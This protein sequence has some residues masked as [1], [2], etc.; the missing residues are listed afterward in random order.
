MEFK[1]P[2]TLITGPLGSGKT[3]LLSRILAEANLR[4]AVVMNEFGEL[5][6]DSR[7][8][9]GKNIQ[10][11]ELAGGC[12]CCSHAGE[13][14]AAVR[15]LV[16]T[17]APEWILLEATGVAE[18]DALVYAV[19]ESLTI[20]RL[21]CVICIV[22]AHAAVHYPSI[23][24]AERSQLQ[25][26][27][28][29]L[30]N[31]TDLVSKAELDGVRDKISSAASGALEVETARC[32]INM[33]LLF[34]P[35]AARNPSRSVPDRHPG[36]HGGIQAFTASMDA[37]LDRA[38]FVEFLSGLPPEVF[39]SKGFVRFVGEGEWVYNYVAGR[40]DFEEY[41][42]PRTEMV[43]IGPGI[44]AVKE[45]IITSLQACGR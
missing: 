16:D 17:V 29:I 19:E 32:A 44:E 23:G 13:L 2:I 40:I 12:V 25:S 27:D 26:A 7:V 30:I 28:L 10:Y 20:V 38:A 9:E 8:I 18:A 33:S 37:P 21:D 6:V 1:T 24:Y 3:T 42:A 14:D 36:H 34:G 22:D 4:L 45:K 39:R 15:E 43:F 41:P 31:K 11:V 5:S 35:D